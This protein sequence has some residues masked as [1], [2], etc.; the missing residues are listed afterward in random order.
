VQVKQIILLFSSLH[1]E[2]P[3]GQQALFEESKTLVAI[4]A[5]HSKVIG[6][7]VLQ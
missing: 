5:L 6:L 7:H 3:D 4:H 1:L 2:Q